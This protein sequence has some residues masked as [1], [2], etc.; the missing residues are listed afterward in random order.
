[1]PARLDA[2][3]RAILDV[4]QQDGRITNAALAQQ[5][6][7]SASACLRRVRQLEEAGVID[8]YV[9]LLDPREIG[10]GTD[11][12]VE[13]SLH[14]QAEEVLD[15]F[16]AVVARAPE[17][18]SCHLMAGPADYLVH[19]VVSDVADY[20]RLHRTHLAKLPGVSNLRSTFAI[21]AVHTST[22]HRLTGA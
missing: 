22:A 15:D 14:N 2:T 12:F 8:R 13:I 5:V 17:V 4:L 3:D 18:M 19:V 6:H 21:R 16:E 20:E 7:L 1:M 11:V 10:R 9:A